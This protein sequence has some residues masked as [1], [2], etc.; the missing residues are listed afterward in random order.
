MAVGV[1]L[2]STAKEK[3]C[4]KTTTK[5]SIKTKGV[6]VSH[7]VS[8]CIHLAFEIGLLAALLSLCAKLVAG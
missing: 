5:V 1:L 7:C 3:K 8:V 6:K 2:V 4:E